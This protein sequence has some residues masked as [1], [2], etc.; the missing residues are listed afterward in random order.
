MP[1][2]DRQI[3]ELARA[4]DAYMT[5]PNLILLATEIE[6]NLGNI[7]PDGSVQ[8]RA[9]VLLK[10]LNAARPPR[11]R[12]LLEAIAA[13]DPGEIR[14]ALQDLV[15]Q[16][17]APTFHPSNAHDALLLGREGFFGRDALRARIKEFTNPTGYTSH[18]LFVQGS[19]PGGKTYSWKY[20]NHC[21][22]QAGAVPLQ[23]RLKGRQ[24]EPRSLVEAI[25]LL[26]NQDVSTLPRL[27]DQPQLMR[28]D[29]LVIWLQ[30]KLADL[31]R[32]YWL[33]IDDLNEPDVTPEV[34][35]CAYALA[36]AVETTKPDNLWIALLGY[37]D[38]I[39]DPDMRFCVVDTANFPTEQTLAND[40]VK[41]AAVSTVPLHPNKAA[42]IAKLF[43]SKYPRID[44]DAMVEI[45]HSAERLGEKLIQGLQP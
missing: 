38:R 22:R 5:L 32:P 2:S 30:G 15:N 27:A 39:V 44:R 21:A 34:R 9:E 4:I 10:H 17:L 45:T 13:K 18:V 6:V 42:Q 26:L 1:L 12:E 36:L 25:G 16:L 14:A 23:I 3:G 41:L 33:V 29:A 40:F 11:D 7:A 8:T 35:A 37:N 24:Y 19:D 28:M 20:L 31:K 43:F